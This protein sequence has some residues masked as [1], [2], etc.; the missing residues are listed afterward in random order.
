[1]GR[2]VTEADE[3]QPRRSD[4]SPGSQVPCVWLVP[5]D[6]LPDS[7]YRDSQSVLSMDERVRAER[8]RD[9]MAR[10]EFIMGRT[11]LRG[12]L[13]GFG[14]VT[15]AELVFDYTAYGKPVARHRGH[16]ALPFFNVSHTRGLAACAIS[17]DRP[18]GVDVE[19]TGRESSHDA[20]ANSM[21]AASERRLVQEASDQATARDRFF[22]LWTLKE[23]YVKAMGQGISLP[24]DAFAFELLDSGVRAQFSEQCP[25]DAAD[26]RFEIGS[27]TPH[28][29]LAVALG[30]GGATSDAAIRLYWT[31][32][33]VRA[34][35]EV[36]LTRLSTEILSP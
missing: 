31:I 2:D 11:L 22:T 9:P 3:L 35:G 10:R 12:C 5:L 29:R 15:A 4:I 16:E 20:L 25:D 17:P 6:K 30:Q 19:D 23:A 7:I 33:R 34:G 14:K 1:M 28:H 26:W 36:Q 13:A 27:P 21:F 18:V 8:F 24:L 32:P